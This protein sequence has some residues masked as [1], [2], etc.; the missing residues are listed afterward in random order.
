MYYIFTHLQSII[1]CYTITRCFNSLYLKNSFTKR[2]DKIMIIH[3]NY[4]N[5]FSKTALQNSFSKMTLQNSFDQSISS[6]AFTNS[7]DRTILSNDLTK[8]PCNFPLYQAKAPCRPAPVRPRRP[9][10][11]GRGKGAGELEMPRRAASW[12]RAASWKLELRA[13]GPEASWKASC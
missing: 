6:N 2:I 13:G 3:I 7:F 9:S 11:P 1:M 5:S 12:N 4:T 8:C 10:S